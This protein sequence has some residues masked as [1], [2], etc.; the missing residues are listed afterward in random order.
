MNEL[1]EPLISKAIV[2]S[3][4]RKLRRAIESDV[5]MIGAGPAGLTAAF[6]AGWE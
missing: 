5:V 1:K 4:H 2:D 6:L 3:Y